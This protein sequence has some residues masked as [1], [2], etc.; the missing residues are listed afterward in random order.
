MEFS[1]EE[2]PEISFPEDS[3]EEESIL[4]EYSKAE[5]SSRPPVPIVE[6]GMTFPRKAVLIVA[7][8]LAVAS[9][10]YLL[11]PKRK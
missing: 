5:N 7:I 3:S 9:L 2:L 4:K 8:L 1:A 10:V 11:I 6:E